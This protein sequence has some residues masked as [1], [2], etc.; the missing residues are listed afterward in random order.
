MF[1]GLAFATFSSQ[2]EGSQDCHSKIN[3]FKVNT[4]RLS[5]CWNIAKCGLSVLFQGR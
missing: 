4:K 1:I 3:K 5:S 2:I